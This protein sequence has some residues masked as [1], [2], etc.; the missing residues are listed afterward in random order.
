MGSTE[1]DNEKPPHSVEIKVP[2]AVGRFAVTFVEWDA[3]GL[4]H[5]PNDQGWGRGRRPVINVSCEHAK[6][7]VGWL[8]QRTRRTYRLLSEAEWEYCCRAGTTTR[9]AFGDNITTSQAQFSEGE[10][11]SA[12]RTAEVGT[13]PPNAWGLYDMHGNVWEWCADNWH[14]DYEGAPQDGA[15][16]TG[17][18]VSSRILRGGSWYYGMRDFLRSASRYKIHP[19]VLISY[20]GFRVARTL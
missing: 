11:G 20:I 7:Y 17:G 10:L 18:D 2:F 9:Y 19:D 8:S 14:G 1:H 13:F 6:A 12:G 16:W 3:A 15:I 4:P 5:K